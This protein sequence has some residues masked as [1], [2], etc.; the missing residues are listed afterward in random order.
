[1]NF[2]GTNGSDPYAGLIQAN[3]GNFYGVTEHGGS[4][5]LVSFSA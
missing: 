1:M 5:M 4:W 3:D 2:N